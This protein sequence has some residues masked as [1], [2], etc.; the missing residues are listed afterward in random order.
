M[1][2]AGAGSFL[3]VGMPVQQYR[4]GPG[5]SYG[6]HYAQ[7]FHASFENTDNISAAVDV[8]ISLRKLLQVVAVGP[9]VTSTSGGL[10]KWTGD[11]TPSPYAPSTVITTNGR[12]RAIVSR[13]VDKWGGLVLGLSLLVVLLYTTIYLFLKH[14]RASRCAYSAYDKYSSNIRALS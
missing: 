8:S 12:G 1:A 13:V 11:S 14:M 5:S 4:Q 7:Q 10:A 9:S 3:T 2:Y 6:N